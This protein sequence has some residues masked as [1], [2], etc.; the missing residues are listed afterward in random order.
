MPRIPRIPLLTYNEAMRQ[1]NLLRL[2]EELA[3]RG[4]TPETFKAGIRGRHQASSARRS[5]QPICRRPWTPG[6]VAYGVVLRGFRGLLRWQTQTDTYFPQEISDRVRVIACLTT[7]PNIVHSDSLGR[8]PVER[9]S[10]R[11]SRRPL[12]AGGRRRRR[13]RLGARRPTPR[14]G[15][16]EIVIRARE[17]TIGIPSE[18]RQALRDGTN[19]FER[20]LPGPDRMYPDT[21]LPPKQIAAERLDRIRPRS[22]GPILDARSLVPRARRPRGPGRAAVRLAVRRPLRERRSAS[23]GSI[24]KLA[25]VVLVQYPKRLKK[26]GLDRGRLDEDGLSAEIFDAAPGPDASHGRRPG[27]SWRRLPDG[28]P[29]PSRR[30]PARRRGRGDLTREVARDRRGSDG[31][32]KIHDAAPAGPTGHGPADGRLARPRRRRAAV[33]ERIGRSR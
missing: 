11:P 10:G 12:G 33:A 26:K 31:P 3:R 5:Y 30:A 1:W 21:D 18:T 24:P 9:A 8:R 28:G 14:L 2:R 22:A 29:C 19:G 4:I 7:L 25:A 32:P 16:Q 13:R 15:A 27:R 17:A 20:I 6:M 23:G